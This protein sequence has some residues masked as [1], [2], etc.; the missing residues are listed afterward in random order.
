MTILT[1]SGILLSYFGIVVIIQTFSNLSY[2]ISM[3]ILRAFDFK[4]A[5][6]IRKWLVLPPT[7]SYHHSTPYYVGSWSFNIP[8]R[9][10]SLVLICFYI[11]NC[12]FL[13]VDY[14][15]MT[16]NYD[17]PSKRDQ[18]AKFIAERSSLIAI[19]LVPLL[20]MFGGR[21][22]LVLWST[23]QPLDTFI[24]F[25]KWIGR[26]VVA[27]LII[28]SVC[29]TINRIQKLFL[30]ASWHEPYWIWGFCAILSGG[31]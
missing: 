29:Y 17:L 5:R 30:K 22:N 28:H 2:V 31:F 26:A 9:G 8:T 4:L 14:R 13:L 27:N 19:S 10:N 1:I 25:H 23:A 12:V 3:R 21:N 11:L 18:I 7:F 20:I 15:I 6:K 16:P 24:V